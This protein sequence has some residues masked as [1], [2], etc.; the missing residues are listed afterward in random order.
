MPATPPPSETEREFGPREQLA[1][2]LLLG[3]AFVV[4][5]NETIMGVALPRLMEDLEISAAAGQWLTT[6]FLLTMSVVIPITGLL[7]RR[8]TTRALFL[9]AM[10]LFTLGTL[11]SAVAPGFGLLLVGRVVQA[12]GTAIMMPLLMTTVT[13]LVPE[14]QRGRLM[15]RI[16][17]VMSVAPAIGPTISGLILQW[18]SWRWL[19]LVVLPIAALSL[20][21]GLLRLP[22]VGQQTRIR[23]DV[24]SVLLAALGF[25]GLVYGLSS[26][27]EQANGVETLP[28]AIPILLGLAAL[29]V[30]VWRQLILQRS[31]RALL[32]L[33]TFLTRPFALSVVLFAFS[34]MALFGSLILLPIYVQQ[35][36]GYE[37]LEAGLVL[38]PGGLLMGLLGP[39]VGR[40]VDVRGARSVLVP[41]SIVA[42]AA[43]WSFGL[44]SDTSSIWQV[45]VSHLLLSLGLAG[46]FTPLFSVSLGSLPSRLASYGSATIST[47]QQVAGAAGTALFVT[48]MTLVS[49]Q[50]AGSPDAVD[51]HAL[52]AGTRAAF[53]LGGVAA[54]IGAVIAFF[55]TEQPESRRV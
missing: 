38:L 8:F 5:L 45:L 2:W 9:T 28:P 54:T 51:P 20:L 42:A 40:M 39:F 34:M 12:G 16:A 14:R 11:L 46:M 50:A 27:G 21:L 33:R 31:D 7:I 17:I 26:I 25:G 48:V 49:N 37:T 10:T 4:M 43:L 22:N 24:L 35:V 23:I 29:A 53:L 18:L 30:F 13:T 19:F 55:V 52:A 44:L 3:S 1:I 32:D 6:A 41:G 15:G 47:V 36:L